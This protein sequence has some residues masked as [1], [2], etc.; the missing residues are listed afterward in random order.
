MNISVT[1]LGYYDA[2]GITDGVAH[3][4]GIY[5]SNS[6]LVSAT[7]PVPTTE[8]VP[9]Y[10]WANLSKPQTLIAGQ[11]YRIFGVGNGAA[12][13]FNPDTEFVDPRIAVNPAEPALFFAGSSL[14][15]NLPNNLNLRFFTPYQGPDFKLSNVPESSSFVLLGW[16]GLT[17]AAFLRRRRAR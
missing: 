15:T 12:D 13:Y 6:L 17:G 10:I 3:D 14:P 4:V 16:L 8:T 7:V 5:Q 9:G 11:T 1:A 2:G